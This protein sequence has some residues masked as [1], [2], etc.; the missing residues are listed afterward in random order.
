[1]GVPDDTPGPDRGI[2]FQF[3]LWNGSHDPAGDRV[4]IDQSRAV[5]RARQFRVSESRLG[6]FA[7]TPTRG[8]TPYGFLLTK[9]GPILQRQ[10]QAEAFQAWRSSPKK[11]RSLEA[12]ESYPQTGRDPTR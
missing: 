2:T 12:P 4:T 7:R 11:G 3:G 6:P 9:G 5:S 1:M 10:G 8:T